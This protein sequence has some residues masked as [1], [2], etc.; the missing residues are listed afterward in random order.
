M[1]QVK[2][3]GEVDNNIVQIETRMHVQ[4]LPKIKKHKTTFK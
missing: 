4:I 2:K 3:E 1:V